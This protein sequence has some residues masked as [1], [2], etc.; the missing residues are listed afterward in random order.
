M[1]PTPEPRRLKGKQ[2]MAQEMLGMREE[3]EGRAT[4]GL[5]GG[6]KVQAAGESQRQ[7]K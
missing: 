4:S 1:L 6:L 7:I 2:D 3:G 5:Q